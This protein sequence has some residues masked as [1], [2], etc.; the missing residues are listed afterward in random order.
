MYKIGSTK[1]VLVQTKT[2]E[3]EVVERNGRERRL[4]WKG[5][6][7]RFN[8]DINVV[9]SYTESDKTKIEMTYQNT[10]TEELTVLLL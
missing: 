3:R 1:R 4:T 8:L 2:E 10:F 6:R 9:R 5:V 7:S